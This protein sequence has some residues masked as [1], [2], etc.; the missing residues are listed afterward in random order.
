MSDEGNN[1]APAAEPANN[2]P[3]PR[4]GVAVWVE[5]GGSA[6]AAYR[7]AGGTWRSYAR[8]QELK[9]PVTMLAAILP[10]RTRSLP[11]R[12]KTISA[13]RLLA[14][15]YPILYPLATGDLLHL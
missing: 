8:G 10:S 11:G 5:C 3:L 14:L 6:T 12:P 15:L 1:T 7:D 13:Q 4:P 9:P 2:A